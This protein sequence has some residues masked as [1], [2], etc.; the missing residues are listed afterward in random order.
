MG[1]KDILAKARTVNVVRIHGQDLRFTEL[2]YEEELQV[3]ATGAERAMKILGQKATED[4]KNE[5]STL[6]VYAHMLRKGGEEVNIDDFF[7]LS[8]DYHKEI[9]FGI[10]LYLSDQIHTEAKRFETEIKAKMK[11]KALS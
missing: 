11:E 3:R 10:Q 2:G 7:T 6:M 5:Y 4:D 9:I 1:L 8:K